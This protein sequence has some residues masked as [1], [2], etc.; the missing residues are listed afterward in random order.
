MYGEFKRM[1]EK[2]VV[3]YLKYYSCIRPEGRRKT[4]KDINQDS[5]LPDYIPETVTWQ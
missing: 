2:V 4:K 3:A 1:L 5:H